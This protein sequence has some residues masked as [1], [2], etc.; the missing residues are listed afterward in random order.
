MKYEVLGGIESGIHFTVISEKDE[1]E[2]QNT[3]KSL[4]VDNEGE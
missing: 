4:D 2:E 3:K 1:T